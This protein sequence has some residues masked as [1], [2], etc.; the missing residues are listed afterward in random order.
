MLK[1]AI[2]SLAR[3]VLPKRLRESVFHFGFGV[4]PERFYEFAYRYAYAASMEFGLLA[5]K[6]RGLTPKIIVDV[7]AFEG[8]WTVLAHKIWPD[9][10]IIM[11]EAN[12]QKLE[13]L[14]NVSK[15][16]GADLHS[17]LL[18]SADGREVD[19]F[20]MESGS[21]VFEEESSTPR[22]AIRKK[23][24]TLDSL[25]VHLQSVDLLKL[26]TQGFELE[27]LR[28]GSRLLAT[29]Q[30][31]LMEVSLIQINRGCPLI[32][33]VLAFMKERGFQSYDIL[34]IHRR[35]LDGATNQID[36]LFVKEN[37]P[38]IADKRFV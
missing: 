8:D 1:N 25:L 28:G 2:V 10:K 37:S 27:V 34:E 24:Q 33:E 3:R 19:F 9:A 38:L 23:T 5:A 18:G 35:L 21:S 31:V 29:A 12:E 14:S 22:Q 16:V 32:H 30:A 7:G 17:A 26:D 15:E 11:V 4:A 6:D 13:K 20:V 36:L